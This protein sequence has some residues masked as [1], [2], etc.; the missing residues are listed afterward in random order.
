MVNSL[1]FGLWFEFQLWKTYIKRPMILVG[2]SLGATVAVDFTAT[3]PEA[4][5]FQ[6]TIIK[7]FWIK[8]ILILHSVNL[9][10]SALFR[11]INWF[12]LMP[13]RILKE[14]VGSKSYQNPSLTLGFVRKLLLYSRFNVCI[15]IVVVLSGKVVKVIPSAPFGQRLSLLFLTLIREHRLD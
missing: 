5:N 2:P 1:F 8:P 4:V 10:I 7:L 15:N 12:L 14:P 3:Y 11:L 6:F 9:I 13:M